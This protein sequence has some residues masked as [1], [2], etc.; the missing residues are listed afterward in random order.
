MEKKKCYALFIGINTYENEKVANLSGCIQDAQR[1]LKYIETNLNQEK[2]ELEAK[3]LF[4]GSKIL[5]T[6]QNIIENIKT[7]LGQ[8]TKEDM[9][10]LFY[11]GHGSKEKAPANFKEADGNFQTLVPCD[12]RNLNSNG[13]T[14]RNI[15]DK[16]LRFL[17]HQLWEEERPEIVFIQ[18]SCHST[19]ASRASEQLTVVLDELKALEQELQEETTEEGRTEEAI[20]ASLQPR[21][22][23]PTEVEKRGDLW[24]KSTTEELLTIYTGFEDAP[25]WIATALAKSN[26]SEV[27]FDLPMAEHIHLAACDKHQFAYEIPLKG[28]VFTSNLLDILEASQNTI[29][30]QDLFNRIRMNIG[31][32]Y[33]QTPDL[34]V[35][36]PDFQ[37]RHELFLGELLRHKNIP[38]QRDID[39]FNGFYPVVPKGRTGWQIKAGELE[40]LPSLEGQIKAIPIE[41]FLQDQA[42]TGTSNAVIDYVASGYSQ[43]T[44]TSAVFD[45]RKHR[46]QL[47]AKIPPKY[48]RRWRVS[49]CVDAGQTGGNTIALFEDYAPRKSLKN[50]QSDGG[51]AVR[52]TENVAAA[53]FVVKVADNWLALYQKDGTLV[54]Y[55]TALQ[56]EEG[57][58]QTTIPVIKKG[59]EE[60]L[61]K[62]RKGKESPLDWDG[63]YTITST[64]KASV[65]PVFDYLAVQYQKKPK[66]NIQVFFEE[67]VGENAFT[68]FQKTQQKVLDYYAPFINWTTPEK[69]KYILKTASDGFVVYPYHNGETGAVPAFRKTLG[70]SIKDGYRVII[71]LQ[72]MCKWQTVYHLYNKLQQVTLAQHQFEFEFKLYQIAATKSRALE[73]NRLHSLV[74][75]Q[76]WNAAQFLDEERGFSQSLNELQVTKTPIRFLYNELYPSTL[77]LDF[78]LAMHHLKGNTNVYVSTLLLDS[79]YAVLPLQ[80][81]MGNNLLPPKNLSTTG[82][83]TLTLNGLELHQPQQMKNFPEEIQEVTFYLKIFIA[84]QR[85]DVS[86]LLQTGLPA[87]APNL[88]RHLEAK[89]GTR[90]MLQK[91][92]KTEETGSWLSFTIPIVVEREVRGGNNI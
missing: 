81:A 86:G 87:P 39:V 28:G 3:T 75:V 36:S 70:L 61:Y 82:G 47:Y 66:Q 84:Y 2:Y 18:D 1:L 52:I 68:E 38:A 57:G 56:Y 58:E 72:K 79:N 71:A 9:I 33:Q 64:Q 53:N 55:A 43:V 5:P 21:F 67:T 44:F 85:F 60:T 11:A 32:V 69:A 8:A 30:Y 89:D 15:L 78:D 46:N 54:F 74:N 90:A 51:A 25:K 4:T 48:M 12:A 80:K 6:R 42:L 16:E 50:F 73:P 91:P 31:G 7:H 40:L 45:R 83:G 24:S 20:I 27:S 29:S 65:S 92:P 23:E 10:L 26:E 37:K 22:T 34:Y 41:V 76:S 13:E 17:L 77:L 59:T 14:I 62:Y 63:N 19:G 49:I 88:I 35:H